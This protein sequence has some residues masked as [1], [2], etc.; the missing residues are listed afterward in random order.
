MSESSEHPKTSSFPIREY[1]DIVW[2]RRWG[3]VLAFVAVSCLG[4]LYTMRQPKVY[5][6]TTA[7]IINPESQTINPFE[8]SAADQWYLR[9]T[10]YDTQL[11]VLQSRLVAQ[12]VVDDLGL[13]ND[14]AFL[15]LSQI[16]DPV[17]LQKKMAAADPVS[18]LLSKLKVESVAGTRLANIRVRNEN[19]ELAA[20]LAN[21]LAAAYSAQNSEHRSAS[22]TATFDFIEK[23]YQENEARLAQSRD[24]LNAFKENHKIL[25]SNPVEQQKITNQ[26]LDYLNTKRVEIDTE[27]QRAGY[28]LSELRAIEVSVDNVHAF[29]ILGGP[30][31]LETELAEC[32]KLEEKKRE[33][34]ITYLEKSPQVTGLHKQ[35]ETCK[36]SVLNGMKNVIQGLEA[37]YQALVKLDQEIHQEISSLQKEALELD[38][39]RLLYEQFESQRRNAESLYEQ[40][41]AK[42]NEVSLNQRLE[43][44]NIRILDN[45]AVPTSPVSPNL[46]INGAIT[47]LAAVIAGFLAV[48][49]LELFDIS[50]RNQTDIEERVGLPFLGAVPKFPK[51]RRYAGRNAYRFILENPRSPIAECMRTLLTTLSFLIKSNASH[52]LLITSAQPLEGKTMTSLNLAVTA[53]LA[54]KRVVLLEADMRRPRIYQALNIST[55]SGLNNLLKGEVTLAEA[56]QG[57]EVDNLKLLPCGEIPKNP[58][59]LFQSEAFSN[60]LDTLKTQ[61]D[62]IIIDSPPV[63]VVT[64][65]LIIAQH[66]H[67]VIVVS[68]AGVTPMPSLVRTRELLESVNAP[69]TGAVLNDL[70]ASSHS[71]YGGYYYY[72]KAYRDESS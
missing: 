61:F 45:A 47:L 65:A 7:V 69:I 1:L 36:A 30:Q 4:V 16:K 27:K 38:Q 66:V 58:A 39:L 3:F 18:I 63:T 70:S 54:G 2:R 21:T 20:S 32:R 56:L 37:H 51:N 31:T 33:L 35:I 67:G 6:A 68:R 8:S 64:D 13:A 46:L 55:K 53:A 44:N 34:L 41:Q 24:A 17:L 72:H 62:T 49:L 52:I 5:E 22:L 15:G 29:T 59:D 19:P 10:Y 14:P 25:Y 12:R 23:Q 42:L 60:L 48:L 26:R 28:V 40:S 57:T 71:Y 43:V 11:R 9:D 50:I